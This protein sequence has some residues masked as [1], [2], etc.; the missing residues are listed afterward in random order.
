MRKHRKILGLLTVLSALM[1]ADYCNAARKAPAPPDLTA[2]GV[3]DPKH[4]DFNLGPTGARGWAWGRRGGSY[5][6]RQIL[7]TEIAA[8]SPASGVLKTGDVVLGISGKPF[9]DD[10]RR[11][12]GLAIG[13]AEITGRLPLLIWRAG[14]KMNVT[15]RLKIL[16]TYSKTWPTNCKKSRAIVE[17]GCK[18]IASTELKSIPGDINALCLLA[19]GDKQYLPKIK[20]YAHSVATLEKK[21]NFEIQRGHFCWGWGYRSIFLA[22]YYLATGDKKVLPALETYTV[23]IARSQSRAGTWGHQGAM[24]KVNGGKLH[25]RLGG[26]GA[27]NAAGLPCFVGMVLATEKCGIDNAVIKS[28]VKTSARFFSFYAN[29]SSIPYGF[30]DPRMSEH[31]DNGK[32]C[33]GAFAFDLLGRDGEARHFA[34][35]ALASYDSR[36]LGHT[37]NFFSY[38]WGPTGVNRIGPKALSAFMGKQQWYYDLA[39][40]HKGRFHYQR[41][42]GSGRQN[43]SRWDCTGVYMM[44]YTMPLKKTYFSGRGAKPSNIL[45]D[46]DIADSITAG[47]GYTTWDRG[48]AFYSAKS[49]SQLFDALQSWSPLARRRAA[50]AL[51]QKEGDFTLR[52]IKMLRSKDQNARF[53]ACQVIRNLAEPP[54]ATA[55]AL[56]ALLDDK[57]LWLRVNAAQALGAIGGPAGRRAAPKMLAM[58]L[59]EDPAD[60]LMVESRFLGEV[61]FQKRNRQGKSGL[62]ADSI[63][64]ADQTRLLAAAKRILRNPCGGA[65]ASVTTL[66]K[67]M[68]PKQLKPI[69]PEIIESIRKPGWSVMFSNNVREKGLVFLAENGISEGLDELMK[70]IEPDP[71]RGN[72]GYWFAPRVIKY[73]KHYR[74]AAKAQLPKLRQYQE[75]Y[76]TSRMLSKNERFL[77]E[78]TKILDLIKKDANP[79]NLRSWKTL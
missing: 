40:D 35:W 33:M 24:P 10:C 44:A 38:L 77:K 22:E 4:A 68:T 78:M 41:Q 16:G 32:N 58:L 73:F 47:S 19:S 76:K 23:E 42:V 29:R 67:T 55:G 79:P 11:A 36:E 70:I 27:V 66:Y 43:Y 12:F 34:R 31:D 5:S 21:L 8:D 64:G 72:E 18:W 39:R 56:I 62:L 26:Y 28:A 57:D 54:A 25:G 2:G 63:V 1:V 59:N 65:R 60:T 46:K 17:Q 50:K 48:D 13:Q 53:G 30:H 74:G 51:A 52:L 69:M 45:N 15:L 37:G 75:A 14:K 71:A 3:R 9:D 6:S 61:L 20:A 7:I 49:V